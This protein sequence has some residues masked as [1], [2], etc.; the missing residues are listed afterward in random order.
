L[1]FFFHR[2]YLVDVTGF[3]E[4]LNY[5]LSGPFSSDNEKWSILN[6][7]FDKH[8]QNDHKMLNYNNENQK[9]SSV[10]TSFELHR[11]MI[12]LRVFF[13]THEHFVVHLARK[14]NDGRVNDYGK[15]RKL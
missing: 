9:L 14:E 3:L 5:R 8:F 1:N 10:P 7:L 11:L 13:V 15:L 12:L 6:E 4:V 2:L